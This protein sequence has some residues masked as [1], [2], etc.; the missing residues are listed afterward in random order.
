MGGSF[1]DESRYYLTCVG[2]VRHCPCN[3]SF[4]KRLRRL[5]D[6]GAPSALSHWRCRPTNHLRRAGGARPAHCAS[7]AA[8]GRPPSRARTAVLHFDQCQVPNRRELCRMNCLN[9]RTA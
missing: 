5:P 3:T 8:N 4:D 7:L 6:T 2:R 9:Q 1:T